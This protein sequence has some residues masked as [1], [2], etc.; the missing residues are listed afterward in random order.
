MGMTRDRSQMTLEAFE[1]QQQ[2]LTDAEAAAELK[3]ELGPAPR[4][5]DHDTTSAVVRH[6]IDD[7]TTPA[8]APRG[9]LETLRKMEGAA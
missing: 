7:D 1:P 9:A 2:R 5:I 6:G 3:E 4:D 8:V